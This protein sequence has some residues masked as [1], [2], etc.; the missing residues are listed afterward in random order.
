MLGG[1]GQGLEEADSHLS[2]GPPIS[3]PSLSLSYQRSEHW[4]PTPRPLSS[5][6]AHLAG[7]G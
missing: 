2:P 1:H 4:L 3:L 5:I 6:F 7:W